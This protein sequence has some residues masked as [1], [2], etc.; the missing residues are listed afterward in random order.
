[1]K[2]WV[3]CLRPQPLLFRFRCCCGVVNHVI[4]VVIIITFFVLYLRSADLVV[5]VTHHF[6]KEFCLIGIRELPGQAQAFTNAVLDSNMPSLICSHFW[7][8]ILNRLYLC[9]I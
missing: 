8:F 2:Q 4:G 7:T 1:M 6:R 5:L 3:L 9:N